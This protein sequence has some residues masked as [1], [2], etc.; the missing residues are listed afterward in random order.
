MYGR[1]F[2]CKKS[3][4]VILYLLILQDA[5]EQDRNELLH[6]QFGINY[7]A[8]LAL[9]RQGTCIFK[10]EVLFNSFKENLLV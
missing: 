4:I 1:M 10:T 3:S 2:L 5:K 8:S 6:Q 9:F 7:N